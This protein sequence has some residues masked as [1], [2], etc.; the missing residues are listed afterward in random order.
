MSTKCQYRPTISTVSARCG[1]RLPA[2]RHHEERHQ[3]D[4]ADAHV[5]AVEAGERVEGRAEDVRGE[6][7]ALPVEGRELVD[8]AGDEHGAEQRGGR[9][10]DPVAAARRPGRS[11]ATASTMVSELISSTN[12]LTDVNG[13]SK[14]SCG[15]GP[16]TL[17]WRR[18]GRWRSGRRTAG[19][20]SPRKTHMASL[21]LERPVRGVRG[22]GRRGGRSWTAASVTGGHLLAA[23]APA[24]SGSV[25]ASPVVVAVVVVVA[26]RREVLV[27]GRL[28]GPAED[29]A[30]E[31]PRRR[32]T[33]STRL[34]M[35]P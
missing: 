22:R 10:P 5:D 35:R 14:R 28:E 23:R 26:V 13:M 21:V 30:E 27:V 3:H 25:A 2:E 17:R 32:S 9:Q 34:K 20:P 7:Q 6:A 31:R 33:A 18:A 15:P 29:A 11:T 24:A 8:L 1:P 19:T 4:D 16:S 12:E